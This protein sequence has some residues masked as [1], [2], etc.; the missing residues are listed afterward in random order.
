[1]KLKFKPSLKKWYMYVIP[2]SIVFF[3]IILLAGIIIGEPA[4]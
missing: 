2:G 1:M 4:P 3:G